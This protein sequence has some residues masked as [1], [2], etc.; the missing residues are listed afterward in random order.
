MVPKITKNNYKHSN[1]KY[2]NQQQYSNDNTHE[3]RTFR[4]YQCYINGLI[5]QNTDQYT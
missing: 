1:I 4:K 3:K 2:K 5:N